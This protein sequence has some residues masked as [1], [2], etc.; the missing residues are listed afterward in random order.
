[1]GRVAE[2]DGEELDESW[3]DEALVTEEQL[4]DFDIEQVLVTEE[5][6]ALRK[7]R[8][9]ADDGHKRSHEADAAP[10]SG[11]DDAPRPGIRSRVKRLFASIFGG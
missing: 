2:R 11:E 3:L 6:P 7:A 9:A 8:L 5:V 1:M 10:E 4:L